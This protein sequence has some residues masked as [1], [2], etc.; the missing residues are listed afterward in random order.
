V[1]NRIPLRDFFISFNSADLAYGVAIDSA[2]RRAGF[3]TYFYPNDLGPGGNIPM[4]MDQALMNSAQTLAIYSPD[5][6]KDVAAYSKAELYA[7]WWQDPGGDKRKL[8]P[9]QVRE[10]VVTPLMTMV[11]R[12]DV[13]GLGPQEA[14]SAVIERLNA[15]DET[16]ERARWRIGLALPEIFK[17]AYRP[18]PNFSGRF[19]AL[20]SLYRSFQERSVVALVG[21]PGVG[22][23]TLAAEYCH[24]FGGRYGGVWWVRA[25]QETIML[26]DLQSL[27]QKL[28]LPLS[29]N[30]EADARACL[31]HLASTTKPW[32]L[33]FD[34]AR[35][36]D[37]VRSWLPTGAVRCLVTSR[38]TEF[39]D[40]AQVSRLD[41]WSD[42]A[43]TNYLLSRTRRQDA[44]GADRRW[45]SG[46]IGRAPRWPAASS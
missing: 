21:M 8:I 42:A 46:A 18:N 12:I 3:T 34:N 30:V 15:S 27:G 26:S 11:S 2:L 7:T 45:G 13:I 17:A 35:S 19:E 29:N 5:Y 41:Q 10:T 32:L 31:D 4:W 1:N 25:E 20:E 14:A 22:K 23:T 37:A 33:V 38:F 43:A 16:E 44:G 28:E 39:W 40:I 24:R 36:P 9:V 6:I